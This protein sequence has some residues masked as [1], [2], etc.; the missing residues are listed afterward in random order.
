MGSAPAS[1]LRPLCEQEGVSTTSPFSIGSLPHTRQW[2]EV[3]LEVPDAAPQ[4]TPG[5]QMV[6]QQD[7]QPDLQ[8][9]TGILIAGKEHDQQEGYQ[10]HE[11]SQRLT[12]KRM[13]PERCQ[14]L[15]DGSTDAC[16]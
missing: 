13:M 2:I 7:D 4:V 1:S 12:R 8:V 11:Q 14:V 6:A 15:P 5:T 16:A 3:R 9:A 10:R